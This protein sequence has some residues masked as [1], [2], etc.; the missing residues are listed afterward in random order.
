MNSF[1]I[2]SPLYVSLEVN[3]D[4]NNYCTGCIN[5]LSFS[6]LRKTVHSNWKEIIDAVCDSAANI[7][8]TGGEPTLHPDIADILSYLDSKEVSFV[9]FSHGRIN[10]IKNIL[11]ILNHSNHFWGF[12]VSMHGR[13]AA[14]H[15]SF[16]N[17]K[18]SYQQ[19]IDGIKAIRD[20]K[21]PFFT[22]TVIRDEVVDE[23]ESIAELALELGAET[24]NFNRYL[25]LKNGKLVAT[26]E[27]LRRAIREVE[28]L[29]KE[30][31]YPTY[32]GNCIPQCFE[33]YEYPEFQINGVTNCTIDPIGNVRAGHH[34]EV[35]GNVLKQPIEEIW[36]NH[37]VKSYLE[38]TPA[39]CKEC[40][41]AYTCP[42]GSR[43]L[44]NKLG[45]LQDP[46][47]GQAIHH[48]RERKIEMPRERIPSLNRFAKIR[49]EDF[50]CIVY[51]LNTMYPLSA[52]K[53]TVVE[54]F[55]LEQTLEAMAQSC[56][57]GVLE[58]IAELYDSGLVV[59]N[60]NHSYY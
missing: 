8:V 10:N 53:E 46:L 49:Q 54:L 33:E 26:D 38:N 6:R 47:I 25:G 4:C 44:A 35:F 12:L 18:N 3:Y 27:Q 17:V 32:I 16:T 50:G 51:D 60:Q 56:G 28:R 23:I 9:I 55:A 40:I 41:Y 57:E 20:F 22:T 45:L 43:A 39:V 34:P 15:E 52:A 59:F 58:L 19:M 30:K 31:G 14:T 24:I 2:R 36:R 29:R 42:G 48:P 5:E 7:R 11:P 13:T 21:L 1:N 37:I